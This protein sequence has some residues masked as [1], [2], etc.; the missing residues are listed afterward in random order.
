[1]ASELL[2]FEDEDEANETSL[3]GHKK[4]VP[5]VST[6]SLEKKEGQYMASRFKK[7]PVKI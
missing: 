1:M 5:P 2:E 4:L 3:L 6:A 7:D